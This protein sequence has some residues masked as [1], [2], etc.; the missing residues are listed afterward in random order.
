MELLAASGGFQSTCPRGAR[1]L[2]IRSLANWC[3][4]IHVP[5]RGTTMSST[6]LFRTSKFQSTCPRGARRSALQ[7][8]PRSAHF[9]PR[10]HEG[11]DD[12]YL[13]GCGGIRISI[14]VPTRGT[15]LI[16]ELGD[17][18]RIF[19]STCPRGA[20]LYIDQAVHRYAI[21]IHVPTR[22]TT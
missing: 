12:Q 10:A 22:G 2:D 3:I 14:H 16:P 11:H 7:H 4:S 18:H 17:T 9:N 1:Q 8:I 15:T 5:T 21:S 20:R 13:H 19:Q 6:R